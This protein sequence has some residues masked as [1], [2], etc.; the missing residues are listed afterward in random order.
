MDDYREQEIEFTSLKN[1]IRYLALTKRGSFDL[2]RI[3]KDMGQDAEFL[4][5]WS[6][7]NRGMLNEVLRGYRDEIKKETESIEEELKKGD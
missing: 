1:I 6:G 4:R 3:A 2:A 5:K 7:K